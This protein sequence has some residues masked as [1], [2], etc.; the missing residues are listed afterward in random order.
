MVTLDIFVL[1]SQVLWFT[2]SFFIVVMLPFVVKYDTLK[3]PPS[4]DS[5]LFSRFFCLFIF[6]LFFLF[7]E[8][9]AIK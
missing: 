5:S 3:S 2:Y 6:C 8:A 7:F 4:R 1:L 9:Q